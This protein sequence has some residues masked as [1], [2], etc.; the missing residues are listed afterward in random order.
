MVHVVEEGVQRPHALLD[1]AFQEA[2]FR[3]GDDARHQ[4]EGD[5]PLQRV[6]AAVDG[7]RDAETAENALR[8]LLLAL[9]VEL[10]LPGQPVRHLGVGR[11]NL[12]GGVEHF[13]EDTIGADVHTL[14]IHDD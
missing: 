2:P 13:V 7:E 1:A 6:L 4:V 10:G 12:A 14:H 8:F 11:A 9:Q 3:R 5:E